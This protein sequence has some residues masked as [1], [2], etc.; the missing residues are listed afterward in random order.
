MF[1]PS[2]SLNPYNLFYCLTK[3]VGS[4]LIFEDADRAS[5]YTALVRK[6]KVPAENIIKVQICNPQTCDYEYGT[7]VLMITPTL[8]VYFNDGHL[9]GIEIIH[10]CADGELFY[11]VQLEISRHP[12]KTLSK[13]PFLN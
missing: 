6:F 3:R 8:W 10:H 4:R 11:R 7:V 13:R 1:E 5:L 12:L 9:P 2:R